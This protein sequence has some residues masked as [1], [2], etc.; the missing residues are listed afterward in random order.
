MSGGS[1]DY[2]YARFDDVIG[3]LDQH[4]HL[5]A[6]RDR[7]VGLGYAEDAARET[8]EVLLMLLQLQALLKTRHARLAPVWRAVEWWDSCD[9]GEDEVK[10]ALERYRNG[11]KV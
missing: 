10:K 4:T 8:D 11:E 5:I 7:L 6:M 9:S 2:L 3:E 1:Y